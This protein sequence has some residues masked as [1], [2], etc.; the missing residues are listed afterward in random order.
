MKSHE[1][2]AAPIQSMR[3]GLGGV[4]IVHGL[5]EVSIRHGLRGVGAIIM[6]M[7]DTL[8]VIFVIMIAIYIIQIV[9][10]LLII[11]H[12]TIH[13]VTLTLTNTPIPISIATQ[14]S[15]PTPISTPTSITDIPTP[16]QIMVTLWATLTTPHIA[17][18]PKT[19]FLIL[20]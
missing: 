2:Q 8:M 15:I 19:L 6:M 5:R 12:P 1:L 10:T 4:S 14:T 16:I 18:Q 3:P 11:M 17:L 13:T 7:Q 20:S 9:P